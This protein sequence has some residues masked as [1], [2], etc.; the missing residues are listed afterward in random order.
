MRRR[1]VAGT[2]EGRVSGL[3]ESNPPPP[4]HQSDWQPGW[5]PVQFT[6]YRRESRPRRCECGAGRGGERGAGRDGELGAGQGGDE[7]KLTRTSVPTEEVSVRADRG[8]E[9]GA[10]VEEVSVTARHRSRRR[11]ARRRS[12]SVMP[13]RMS[14]ADEDEHPARGSGAGQGGRDG[15]GERDGLGG[16]DVEED[17]AGRRGA[18]ARVVQI[19]EPAAQHEQRLMRQCMANRARGASAVRALRSSSRTRLARARP[20]TSETMNTSQSVESA[21]R[22]ECN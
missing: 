6:Q 8:G 5:T 1:R 10:A 11:R 2:W 22:R 18:R 3:G 17:D 15:G 16:K 13:T 20:R 12:T 4:S 7:H 21:C 9:R 19:E 14:D